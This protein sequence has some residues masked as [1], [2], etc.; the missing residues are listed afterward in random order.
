MT[1]KKIFPSETFYSDLLM[2]IENSTN[3]DRKG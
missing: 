3:S 1:N 2:E